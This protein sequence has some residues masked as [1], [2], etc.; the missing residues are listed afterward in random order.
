[1]SHHTYTSPGKRQREDYEPDLSRG[2]MLGGLQRQARTLWQEEA[3]ELVAT[4]SLL[5]VGESQP[6]VDP[7][8]LGTLLPESQPVE[9]H[10]FVSLP[11]T[12][13]SP[14][15]VRQDTM[16]SGLQSCQHGG[17]GSA[18]AMQRQLHEQPQRSNT[19]SAS[20]VRTSRPV[21]LRASSPG[22]AVA[23]GRASRWPSPAASYGNTSV[24]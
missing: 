1:M 14:L 18:E 8:A 20:Q 23:N 13:D 19:M 11:L 2:G 15:D 17:L 3:G 10:D 6:P 12:H 5:G 22:Q 4:Q 21:L 16:R 9:L 7:Y 24:A